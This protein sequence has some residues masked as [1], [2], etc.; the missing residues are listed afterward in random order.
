MSMPSRRDFLKASVLSVA[1]LP[2]ISSLEA[3]VREPD[4]SVHRLGSC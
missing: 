2:L 4:A 3:Q 1:T